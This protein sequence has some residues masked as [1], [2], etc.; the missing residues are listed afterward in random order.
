QL[1]QRVIDLHV[2]FFVLRTL[3]AGGFTVVNPCPP[4]K[5]VIAAAGQR[6]FFHVPKPVEIQGLLDARYFA[7]SSGVKI[8]LF[9]K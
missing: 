3:P 2:V 1:S 9:S 7:G 6:V 4:P 5:T 8:V